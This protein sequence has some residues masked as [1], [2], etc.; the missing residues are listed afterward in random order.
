LGRTEEQ[1]REAQKTVGQLTDGIAHDV[2]NL[3]TGIIGSMDLLQSVDRTGADQRPQPLHRR[4]TQ[5]CGTL[6]RPYVSA[7]G[8]TCRITSDRPWPTML[9]PNSLPLQKPCGARQCWWWMTTPLCRRWPGN[10]LEELGYATLEAEDGADGLV[11]LE[12]SA[13]I[14][15]LLT[16]VG[17]P[18][19]RNGR[20]LAEVARGRRPR[21]KVLFITGS[22]ENAVLSRGHLKPGM[23]VT[24]KP[25]AMDRLAAQVRSI[26]NAG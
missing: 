3:L 23:Q 17:L 16:D 20:Q 14:R 25:F 19:G 11:I 22:A 5:V 7:A 8:L 13:R 15:L 6:H 26:T 10:V 1:L 21:L 4:R 2:N 18:G 24:T 9:W 12:S